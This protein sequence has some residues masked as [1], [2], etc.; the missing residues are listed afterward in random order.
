MESKEKGVLLGHLC[1]SLDPDPWKIIHR[2]VLISN[3]KSWVNHIFL[4]HTSI[5]KHHY[6]RNQCY[7]T[8]MTKLFTILMVIIF[9]AGRTFRWL[10]IQRVQIDT[11]WKVSLLFLSS[12]L[13]SSSPQRHSVLPDTHVSFQGMSQDTHIHVPFNTDK[14]PVFSV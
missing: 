7:P 14:Y 10:K 6:S 8:I 1:S 5:C 4:R 12:G 11:Q 3:T 13:L 2:S 9:W